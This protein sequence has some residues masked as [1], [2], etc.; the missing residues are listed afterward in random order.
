MQEDVIRQREQMELQDKLKNAINELESQPNQNDLD[1]ED[2]DSN[3]ES[4]I[5][6]SKGDPFYQA[7]DITR[8]IP[9]MIN[10][11]Q[12]GLLFE[13][14]RKVLLFSLSPSPQLRAQPP[15]PSLLQILTT[16]VYLSAS[17]FFGVAQ[18]LHNSRVRYSVRT[19][20]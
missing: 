10:R 17:G 13:L 16:C 19:V 4:N 2:E 3:S 1:T 11:Q 9:G 5:T 20:N 6:L 7:L 18:S 12:L 8:Q 15:E 14:I